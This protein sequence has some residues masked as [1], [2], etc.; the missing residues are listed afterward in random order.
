MTWELRHEGSPKYLTIEQV[1][2]CLQEGAATAIQ[3]VVLLLVV[4]PTYL[5]LATA[6]RTTPPS[7]K[8]DR[9][10]I[11]VTGAGQNVDITVEDGDWKEHVT[12]EDL[13]GVLRKRYSPGKKIEVKNDRNV[14]AR[15]VIRLLRE[16]QDAGFFD[17]EP[18]RVLIRVTATGQKFDITVED[19]DWKERVTIQDLARALRKRYSPGKEIAVKHDTDMPYGLL[20][21]IQDAVKESGF[22]G[23][24][25][26]SPSILLVSISIVNKRRV[27]TFKLGGESGEIVDPNDLTD[28]FRR[29]YAKG[30]T[31]LMKHEEEIPLGLMK[32]EDE[33]PLGL[34]ARLEF[35]AQE[36]GFPPPCLLGPPK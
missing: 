29:Y 19:G 36:A 1:V 22:G 10:L 25:P 17:R 32:H 11:R 30:R 9:V 15:I 6:V 35:A 26:P 13:P 24:P 8:N 5:A 14:S 7:A 18:G 3:V 20:V 4:C 33:I 28:A 27:I 2:E 16:A 34:L 12:M 31:I 23:H 21:E